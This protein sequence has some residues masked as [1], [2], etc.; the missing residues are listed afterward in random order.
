M[1]GIKGR[2][3]AVGGMLTSLMVTAV[4]MAQ[5]A[6]AATDPVADAFGELET[7]ATTYAGLLVGL[8]VLVVGLLFGIAWIRKARSAH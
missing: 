8:V 4:I 1:D 6:S 7:K 2:V 5:G 3:A